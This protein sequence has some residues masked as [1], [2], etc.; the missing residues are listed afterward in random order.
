MNCCFYWW[1]F[2]IRLKTSRTRTLFMLDHKNSVLFQWYTF[3]AFVMVLVLCFQCVSVSVKLYRWIV[4]T[5]SR[6]T[7]RNLSFS[8]NLPNTPFTVPQCQ[9]TCQDS[10]VL[11]FLFF[12]IFKNFYYSFLVFFFLLSCCQFLYVI[13]YCLYSHYGESSYVHQRPCG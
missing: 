4:T 3:F 10:F 5:S 11:Q 2:F 12:F 1:D 13:W 9:Q 6:T 8:W 7:I